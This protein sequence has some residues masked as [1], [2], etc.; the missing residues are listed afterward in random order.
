MSAQAA[1]RL[2][3]LALCVLALT[4]ACSLGRRPRLAEQVLPLPTR[5]YA[6]SLVLAP[7]A[8][9]SLARI[10][11]HLRAAGYQVDTDGN[12]TPG[13][14][15]ITKGG[16]ELRARRFAYPGS[17]PPEAHIL[18]T[19]GVGGALAALTL[20]SEPTERVVLETP[21]LASLADRGEDRELV[22]L[23]DIPQHVVDAVLMTEDRRFYSHIGVD[24]I[25]M[26][27][28]AARNAKE[29]RIAEGA[30]TITQ[31]LVKNVF[32]SP[33]RTF[34]RKFKEVFRSLWLELRYSKDEILEAYL[35]EIYLGQ[36]GALAIHGI[37]R[38]ARFYFAKD[39][40]ELTLAD[41]ALLAALIQGPNALSPFKHADKARARRNLILDV[42]LEEH[43][44]KPAAHASAKAQK[45]GVRRERARPAFAAQFVDRVRADLAARVDEDA[46][47]RAG[48][49]VFTTL[50]AGYQAAAEAAVADQLATLEQAYPRLRRAKKPLQAGLIALDPRNGDVLAYV[51]GRK[52]LRGTLDRVVNAHRQPGSVFKP[53]VALAALTRG[54]EHGGDPITL[55]T[56]LEDAPLE[57]LVDGKPWSPENHDHRFRGPVTTRRA[58]E[59]SLNVP[60]TRLALETGLV[61]VAETAR[62][63]GVE[64]PLRPI[65]SLALGAFEM[66]P[67]E[68]ARTYSVFAN[69]GTLRAP[70]AT[71]AVRDPSGDDLGGDETDAERVFSEES[72]YLVTSALM[73]AL[74]RGTGRNLRALGV[75]GPFAGKTGTTND[76]RDA[77]FAGYT[78]ELVVVVW[79]GFDDSTLVGLTG[80][81]GAIPVVARFVKNALGG[82]GWSA[83]SP[84]SGLVTT[85]ID[86]A[87]GL[88]AAPWC[89]GVEEVFL[90]E[91]SPTE[92][93]PR[94]E[95]WWMWW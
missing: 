84:P 4:F 68:V 95:R 41:G 9:I 5:V 37:S 31:Q 92:R 35:N 47:S 16:F 87:T 14:F 1:Q 83:F 10:E 81:Q 11:K 21:L 67:L 57:I 75:R 36:D 93:C 18:G 63:L 34:T 17:P 59:D 8:H 60:F 50:D 7:G 91:T 94:P 38:A 44:I 58:L 74:D 6:R 88:L 62:R 26:F 51:G 48:F 89:D 20:N 64:S 54:R 70:R 19:L 49:S 55:A 28:A 61:R 30:S 77:W 33:E 13:Q 23:A 72:T 65:P 56:I 32:L 42:M 43:A 45:L 78:P 39:V 71:L 3:A 53:V 73:G 76:L 27:G 80:A 15:R 2:A 90:R 29:R 40:K 22:R 82:S 85:E 69:G 25:R 24:P 79:V 12:L 46:M 66:T 52:A 86:P